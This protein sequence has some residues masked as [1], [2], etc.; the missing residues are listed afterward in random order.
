MW[1]EVVLHNGAK[2]KVVDVVY[3]TKEGPFSAD[4]PESVVVKFSLLSHAVKPFFSKIPG[5]VAF[6]PPTVECQIG[7]GNK[8]K[9]SRRQ[10]PL[11][12]S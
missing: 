1:S 12:L 3:L 4:L 5:S 2:G 7:L 10:F 11:A 9:M 6:P 8:L